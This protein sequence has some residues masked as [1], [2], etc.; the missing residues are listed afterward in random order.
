MC[1][2]EALEWP[3]SA[4]GL[5]EKSSLTLSATT[6][7][8]YWRAKK[9]KRVFEAETRKTTAAH[10]SLPTQL[11]VFLVPPILMGHQSILKPHQARY[12][13]KQ[14][15]FALKTLPHLLRRGIFAA[16]PF[17]YV[18]EET[19]QHRPRAKFARPTISTS[20]GRMFWKDFWQQPPRRAEFSSGDCC[21]ALA[22]G[23]SSCREAPERL[24]L[25]RRAHTSFA[26]VIA[27]IKKP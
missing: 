4:R 14:G 3:K 1:T 25:Q 10:K 8:K 17:V 22:L 6:W 20:S 24:F 5:C 18:S 19:P 26:Y 21:A 11:C 15:K 27:L 13:D 16:G 9:G 2:W 12:P 23:W 7:F